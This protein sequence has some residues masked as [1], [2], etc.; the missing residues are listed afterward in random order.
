[1]MQNLQ[2]FFENAI[3]NKFENLETII[4]V[5]SDYAQARLD[6]IMKDRI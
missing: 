2:L 4:E 1:M 6:Q 3:K 5:P